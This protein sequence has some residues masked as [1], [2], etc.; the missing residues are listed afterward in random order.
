MLTSPDLPSHYPDV[1]RPE[2]GIGPASSEAPSATASTLVIL[3]FEDF[4]G[5]ARSEIGDYYAEQGVSFSG[6]SI[7]REGEGLN[8]TDFPP[9][10]GIAVVYDWPPEFDG[11]I[12]A[13]FT[14]PVATVG[15]RVT[16][17]R[18]VT[19]E[20]FDVDGNLLGT[21]AL[22]AANFATAGTGVEPNYPLE[23]SASRIGTCAF[24]DGGN[25]FTLDDFAFSRTPPQGP[26][27]EKP[28]LWWKRPIRTK[29]CQLLDEVR[30]S[31]YLG[32]TRSQV[33]DGALYAFVKQHQA[34]LQALLRQIDYGADVR[35]FMEG[36][37]LARPGWQER[38]SLQFDPS[39]T[40]Q[41]SS[42]PETPCGTT[43]RSRGSP[44]A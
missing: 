35:P 11:R 30:H 26:D 7:L 22:P 27:E 23:V 15:A 32:V 41:R 33:G 38:Q 14:R 9:H 28:C 37:T 36:E 19:L 4:P 25:T 5:P 2:A 13:T 3:D 6:A 42:G 12:T 31:N 44:S 10:S 29:S 34:E 40:L 8:H 20:C 39:L 21:D 1:E 43:I 16:G 24:Q 17:N 18:I